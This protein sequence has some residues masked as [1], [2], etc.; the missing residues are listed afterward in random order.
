M[1]MPA[2]RCLGSKSVSVASLKIKQ[3][4]NLKLP[5]PRQKGAGP[6]ALTSNQ[7]RKQRVLRTLGLL[8]NST[9]LDASR[10]TTRHRQTTTENFN[11]V[12]L[13]LS[14]SRFPS[15]F[16]SPSLLPLPRPLRLSGRP[17]STSFTVLHSIV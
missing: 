7:S 17:C 8:I 12:F 11:K 15:P 10:Q 2:H 1:E 4:G 3:C 5:K 13:G 16:S 14:L 9:R 6:F